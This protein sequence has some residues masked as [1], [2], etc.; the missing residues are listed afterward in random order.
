MIIQRKG[1]HRGGCDRYWTRP[2][3]HTVSPPLVIDSFKRPL[4]LGWD[5]IAIVPVGFT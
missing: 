4:P 2:E 1:A 5:D 3:W